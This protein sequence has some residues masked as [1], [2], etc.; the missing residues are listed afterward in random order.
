MQLLSTW[1]EDISGKASQIPD[2][3]TIARLFCFI[4]ACLGGS[5]ALDSAVHCLTVHY[6]GIQQGNEEI[7]RYG[8]LAYGK[9]L[10]DI[11]KA[12]DDPVEAMKSTTLC[13]TMILSLYEVN[14]DFQD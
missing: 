7:T 14:S 5:S 13:A 2:E 3:V 11:Q 6:L 10:C 8:R 1:I 4:P 12:I 9:A